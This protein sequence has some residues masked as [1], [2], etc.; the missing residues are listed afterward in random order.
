MVKVV[1]IDGEVAAAAA[2]GTTSFSG[3]SRYSPLAA[4]R[5]SALRRPSNLIDRDGWDLTG[6]YI[7]TTEAAL[8][9]IDA[10]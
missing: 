3:C 4:P 5:A 10:A 2:D 9:E 1:L 8:A 7:F 6:A